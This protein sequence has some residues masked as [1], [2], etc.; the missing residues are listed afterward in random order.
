MLAIDIRNLSKTYQNGTKA[1]SDIN[2]EIEKGSFFALLGSNGAGKTTT[3][4]IL[5]SLVTKT[6]GN[7][8]IFGIDIDQ[9]INK[10]KT[11][12][13]VVPQEFNF[14]MFEKVWDIVVQQAG[15]YGIPP[16]IAKER[17]EML[18]KKLS[19][20]EK[21]NVYS[22]ELSGGMKRRLMIARGLIHDP[23]ILILDEP[24]AGVDAELRIGMW[25]Y[26]KQVNEAG[27]TILLTTHYLEEV[28]Q[29]FSRAAII[30]DGQIIK[31]DNVKN[32]LLSLDKQTFVIDIKKSNNSKLDLSFDFW[33]SDNDTI[34]IVVQKDQSLNKFLNELS[35][36]QIQILGIRPKASRLEELFL[37]LIKK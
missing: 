32:L 8:K 27:T 12:L 37:E 30:K 34:E 7:V 9:D 2:L 20:W 23:K 15:F 16:S 33:E 24:S 22:R 17:A 1:L 6:A 29:L 18:L 35:D 21:R 25:E 5:T 31:N 4:G 36:K 28:E 13:G 26:L 3:I 11:M 14:N 10:A 19:L